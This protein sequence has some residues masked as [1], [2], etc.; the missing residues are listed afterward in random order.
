MKAAESISWVL[1]DNGGGNVVLRSKNASAF[2][3]SFNQVSLSDGQHSYDNDG[4]MVAPYS[5]EDFHLESLK[6]LPSG[7]LYVSYLWIDDFGAQHQQKTRLV[8]N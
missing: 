6:T 2:Y 1:I 7:Q 8:P 4:G 5:T 3:V